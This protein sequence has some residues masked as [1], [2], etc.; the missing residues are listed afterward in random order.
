[1]LHRLH[2]DFGT[3]FPIA[4]PR[5]AHLNLNA[6]D[7]AEQAAAVFAATPPTLPPSL[8][9]CWWYRNCKLKSQ[10]LFNCKA[11][12]CTCTCNNCRMAGRRTQL[13]FSDTASAQPWNNVPEMMSRTPPA[14]CITLDDGD[15]ESSNGTLG[16][17]TV[18]AH[19]TT[20]VVPR[21]QTTLAL[22]LASRTPGPR[23]S[24]GTPGPAAKRVALPPYTATTTSTGATR[25][26]VGGK[27]YFVLAADEK[28]HVLVGRVIRAADMGTRASLLLL[29]RALVKLGR[30]TLVTMST[31]ASTPR[32]KDSS[33]PAVK[34]AE[35]HRAS[36]RVEPVQRVCGGPLDGYVLNAAMVAFMRRHVSHST[37]PATRGAVFSVKHDL[38][39]RV[40]NCADNVETTRVTCAELD[41][42]GT[43]VPKDLAN[44]RAMVGDCMTRL[45]FRRTSTKNKLRGAKALRKHLHAL[46]QIERDEDLR[47]EVALVR[48]V[49]SCACDRVES[50]VPEPAFVL[51]NAQH[52]RMHWGDDKL[53]V[54][55][56]GLHGPSGEPLPRDESRQMCPTPKALKLRALTER[57]AKKRSNCRVAAAQFREKRPKR[58]CADSMQT[59]TQS[60][61]GSNA[62]KRQRKGGR[63]A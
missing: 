61:T 41:R 31:P 55:R 49:T 36:G 17:C 19:L 6:Y 12:T 24:E 15:T 43:R 45:R 5:A 2:Q 47:D 58:A 62:G 13:S 21:A 18:T 56:C 63:T 40:G 22:P 23:S 27:I 30:E 60:S 11:C 26:K 7:N 4:F 33:G 35:F 37:Q 9:V 16:E 1:M 48:L 46:V 32:A 50:A 51:C 52:Q 8:I 3:T 20:C 10:A 42:F 53:Q 57:E 25:V 29:P 38:V 54:C 14:R 59:Q 28:H 44:M 39:A 34:A